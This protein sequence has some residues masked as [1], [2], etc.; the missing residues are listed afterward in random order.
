MR[1]IDIYECFYRKRENK[2]KKKKMERDNCMYK[3]RAVANER[4]CTRRTNSSTV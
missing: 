2:K 3:L 4:K 1:N